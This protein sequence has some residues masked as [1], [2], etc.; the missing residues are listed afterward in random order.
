MAL[1]DGWDSS[2]QPPH[3]GSKA[4]S[5][6]EPWPDRSTG[7]GDGGGGLGR[8]HGVHRLLRGGGHHRLRLPPGWV[9]PSMAGESFG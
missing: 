9:E 5:E 8:S 4:A 6:A 2:P 7:A 1:L 3:P